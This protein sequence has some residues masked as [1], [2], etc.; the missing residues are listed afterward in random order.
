MVATLDDI[1]K[2]QAR[3][4]YVARM[5]VTAS[6]QTVTA[7]VS[8]TSGFITLGF[9]DNAIGTTLPNTFGEVL[10]PAGITGDLWSLASADSYI[11]AR[12]W[13]FARIYKVGTV[14]LAAT[15]SQF[16]HDTATFPLLRSEFGASNRPQAYW[17]VIQ[18]TTALTTT[19][20]QFTM[21]YVSEDGTSVTGTR[22]FVFPS[23][24]TTQGSVF[25][26]PLEQGDWACRDVTSISVTTA[27]G[28]GAAATIW[29]M[30]QLQ[31]TY[32]AF[33]GAITADYLSGHGLA[34]T[35]H[36]PAV[37]TSGT[38]TSVTIYSLFGSNSTQAGL[39]TTIS[40]LS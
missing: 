14:N 11:S 36:T 18:V 30:E 8:T 2:Q 5:G 23:P 15:G 34:V 38:A 31:P 20:A 13:M 26:L 39:A 25:F 33:S 12:G 27:S 32:N 29:L 10:A 22:T 19:A 9:T 16:T 1:Y 40:V 37:A 7:P 35:N 17:P 21:N 6:P 28:T 4:K 24:T 3:G